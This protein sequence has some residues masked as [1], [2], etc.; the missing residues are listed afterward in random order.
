MH[1]RNS[2]SSYSHLKQRRRHPF[3]RRNRDCGA[4]LV[5]LTVIRPRHNPAS[6][7]R[8]H[9]R[10]PQRHGQVPRLG[11]LGRPVHH[12]RGRSGGRARASA[13]R[14]APCDHRG[15]PMHRGG[16]PASGAADGWGAG[17]F[18]APVPTGGTTYAPSVF[19]LPHFAPP[20][21]REGPGRGGG[22]ATGPPAGGARSALVAEAHRP[23]RARRVA[24]SG[25]PGVEGGARCHIGAV[26]HAL[27]RPAR[28]QTRGR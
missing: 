11:A 9:G 28:R 15:T 6:P 12:H 5:Q 25:E 4:P 22:R 27:C 14:R 23:G 2:T 24:T 8:H 18:R 13:S 26:T 3:N 21:R 20:C 10:I 1:P 16:P 17:C 19:P 7:R